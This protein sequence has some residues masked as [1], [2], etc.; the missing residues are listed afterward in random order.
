MRGSVRQRTKGSWEIKYD[1]GLDDKGVRQQRTRTVVG[2]KSDADIERTRILQEIA[3]GTYVDKRRS[4]KT[5]PTAESEAPLTVEAFMRRWLADVRTS[6]RETWYWRCSKMIDNN[7]VP[8]LGAIPLAELTSVQIR[9]WIDW[10]LEQGGRVKKGRPVSAAHQPGEP[11]SRQTVLHHS[12]VLRQ[13]LD[14]A[15]KWELI[16]KNPTRLVKLPRPVQTEMTALNEEQV[17]LLLEVVEAVCPSMRPLV[18]LAVQTGARR[19]ELIAL[20]WEDIDWDQK[21]LMIC[22]SVEYGKAGKFTLKEPKTKAGRRNIPLSQFAL[23]ALRQQKGVQ[24][25]QRLRCGPAWKDHGF[26]FTQEDGGMLNP[27]R[28]TSLFYQ[29]WQR[30][31]SSGW[32]AGVPRIRFHDLR[33]TFASLLLHKRLDIK[34]ISTMLGHAS[35][36]ITLDRYSHLMPGSDEQVAEAMDRMFG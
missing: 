4:D 29:L 1:I 36:A 26:V 27:N 7:I 8:C 11:L 16:A 2:R 10:S 33:H 28:I 25:E 15:V 18:M 24:A 17:K 34:L 32:V 31:T 22:R 14:V 6:F 35:V 12:R 5:E 23:D 20:K 21:R 19:S 9:D 3:R 30:P 13:A